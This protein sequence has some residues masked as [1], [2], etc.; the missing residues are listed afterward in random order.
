MKCK[1]CSKEIDSDDLSLQAK[2]AAHDDNTV[3]VFFNCPHCA[4]YHYTF[5][6]DFET[7]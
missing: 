4:A 3:E 5:V 1:K 6:D 7:E 2:I